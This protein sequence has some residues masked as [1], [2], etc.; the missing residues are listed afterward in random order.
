VRG[1]SISLL[2]QTRSGNRLFEKRLYGGGNVAVGV[3]FEIQAGGGAVQHVGG[4]LRLRGRDPR[5]APGVRWQRQ[6]LGV[7]YHDADAAVLLRGALNGCWQRLPSSVSEPPSTF[8]RP[9]TTIVLAAA[10]C[11][12]NARQDQETDV[13]VD[14]KPAVPAT[15]TGNDDLG[16]IAWDSINGWMLTDDMLASADWATLIIDV[17]MM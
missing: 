2:T 8:W 7:Q 1:L 10:Y 13:A 5:L 6:I 11:L 16:N 9:T 4:D 14:G 12:R 3:D 15:S 17:S